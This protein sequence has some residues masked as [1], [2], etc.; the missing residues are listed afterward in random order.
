MKPAV[1]ALVSGGLDSCVML[2]ELA[3]EYRKVYPVFIRYGLVW[4]TAELRHLRKFL[5]DARIPRVQFLTVLDLP[6]RDLYGAHWSTTG[7]RVPNARTPDEA[8]Y[9]PG[10]N[11]LLLSKAAVF[12]ALNKIDTIAV[13]SL[14]HNPFPDATPGFFREFAS[15]ASTALNSHVKVIAP[16]RALSKEQVV[17]RGKSLPLN[18]S[19]SCI[20]P[21]RGM[22]CGRCN[23]CAERQHAFCE[24]G[25]QD[26][27]RYATP[28]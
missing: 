17:S 26:L 9:L 13:G 27:T 24:A 1:C 10:R 15:V 14:D 11:L 4:E 19:F 25:V 5:G 3:R 28:N 16:F 8:V 2:A 23:K 22:H 7:R 21:R 6:V 12:C 20:A 18:L